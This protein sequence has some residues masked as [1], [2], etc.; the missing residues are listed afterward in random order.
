MGGRLI[1]ILGAAL[2]GAAASTTAT[3]ADAPSAPAQQIPIEQFTRFDEFGTIKISPD[4]EHLALTTGRYG[5]G[6][7]VFVNLKAKGVVGGLR[8]D[9]PYEIDEFYWV[10]ND[11]VVFTFSERRGPLTA[12]SRTGE[13][14]AVDIDGGQNKLIYGYRAGEQ[15]TGTHMKVRPSSYASAELISSLKSDP[16]NILIAESPWKENGMYWS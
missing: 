8:A 12:P 11:R 14:Y 16:K 7:L 6:A 9:D 15:S 2:I 13:I 4:G 10:S 1:S 3:A 5:R